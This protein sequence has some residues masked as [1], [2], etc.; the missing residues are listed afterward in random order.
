MIKR[1]YRSYDFFGG[2]IKTEYLYTLEDLFVTDGEPYLVGEAPEFTDKMHFFGT[3][4][5]DVDYWMTGT[6]KDLWTEIWNT[7]RDEICVFDE[8]E[9]TANSDSE[10]SF[11]M[12]FWKIYTRT[13]KYY[14]KLITTTQTLEDKLLAKIS[15][16]VTG[17]NRLNDTPD[18][19]GTYNTDDYTS[20]LTESKTT[21]ETDG[22]TTLERLEEIRLRYRDY[23]AQWRREF[24]N[25]FI[26]PLN[27]QGG[28]FI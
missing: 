17:E 14:E 25:L 15:T 6:G 7:Y 19:S 9:L 18:N 20:T 3:N 2:V 27:Y 22:G 5:L 4:V 13:K 23:L 1:C 28:E 21:S 24:S 11:W 10:K 16:T 12:N 26:S 8:E